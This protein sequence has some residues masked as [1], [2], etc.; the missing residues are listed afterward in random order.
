MIRFL[1]LAALGATSTYA[2]LV[3]TPLL[4]GKDAAAPVLA[5]AETYP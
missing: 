4:A 2:A 5:Q 3:A 1:P